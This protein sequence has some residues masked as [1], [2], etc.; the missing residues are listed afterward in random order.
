MPKLLI[1]ALAV[2]LAVTAAERNGESISDALLSM[3]QPGALAFAELDNTIT[4]DLKDAAQGDGEDAEAEAPPNNAT[5][6][7]KG[8]AEMP[9]VLAHLP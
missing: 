2:A 6:P 9:S 5:S 3:E 4:E 7:S 1:F 8:C